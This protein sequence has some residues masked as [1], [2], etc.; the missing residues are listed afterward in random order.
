MM[1]IDNDIIKNGNNVN[2]EDLFLLTVQ[3][4]V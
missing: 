3:L 1:N 4:L 2:N